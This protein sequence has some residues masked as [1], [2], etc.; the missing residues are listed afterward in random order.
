GENAEQRLLRLGRIQEKDAVSMSLD[1]VRALLHAQKF[2]IVHR[3]VKPG[4]MLITP[5]G[6]VK[7]GD[8]GLAKP[9]LA[10][11]ELLAGDG[12]TAGTPFYMSPE[13]IRAPEKIDFR[14]DVYSLG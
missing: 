4:N 1:V 8:M 2:H 5:S 9:M 10:E 3:D 7:L 11:A 13:Q 12:S 14:S 6:H